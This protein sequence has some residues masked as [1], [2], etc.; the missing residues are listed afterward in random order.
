M[1]K[2]WPQRYYFSSRNKLFTETRNKLIFL[3]IGSRVCVCVCV[4]FKTKIVTFGKEEEY[5]R[6]GVEEHPRTRAR[7]V[8]SIVNYV[9]SRRKEKL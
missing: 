9:M 8:R 1:I 2:W 6:V 5:G 4:G 3:F 7:F